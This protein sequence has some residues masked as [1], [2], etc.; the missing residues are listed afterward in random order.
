MKNENRL[1]LL[2]FLHR[3]LTGRLA[4]DRHPL[5]RRSGRSQTS[6]FN[7]LFSFM[8]FFLLRPRKRAKKKGACLPAK[9][10]LAGA[11]RPLKRRGAAFPRTA[12][13]EGTCAADLKPLQAFPDDVAGRTRAEKP[14]LHHRRPTPYPPSCLEGGTV[15]GRWTGHANVPAGEFL[16]ISVS[17]DDRHAMPDFSPPLPASSGPIP[18]PGG[19][20]DPRILSRGVRFPFLIGKGPVCRDSSAGRGIGLRIREVMSPGLIVAPLKQVVIPHLTSYV[21][22]LPTSSRPTP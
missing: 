10:S 9:A 6:I 11:G 12:F 4:A 22:P 3:V 17:I 19:K 15:T 7:F 2:P 1:V 21:Y 5:E 18:L 14:L 13:V 16:S 8:P 20:G